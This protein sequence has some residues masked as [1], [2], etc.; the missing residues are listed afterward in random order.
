MKKIAWVTGMT[1]L[2]AA[3]S[4]AETRAASFTESGDAGQ[5]LNTAVVIP[6]SGE[7]LDS[8]SGTLSGGADGADLFQIFLNGGQTFSATTRNAA[9]AEAV[10]D[11][12]LGLPTNVLLDPQLFLFNSTGR[13]I[14]ANDNYQGSSQATLISGNT[15]FS[16]I[17]S[18]LYFL[19]ISSPGYN[20]VSSGGEIFTLSSSLDSLNVGATG[21][22]GS[23]PLTDFAG[24]VPSPGTIPTTGNYTISLTGAQ[25]V[26]AVPEP[27]SALGI[28]VLGGLGAVSG[29]KRKKTKLKQALTRTWFKQSS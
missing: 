19:A 21:P 2:I 3:L 16:P 11:V 24:T 12:L 1:V 29:W 9:T 15:S 4:A 18:G 13:G 26:Q 10:Q 7:A 27:S 14:S 5:R 17:E 23:L 22:G 25:A 6:G 28:L 20:P 8:I